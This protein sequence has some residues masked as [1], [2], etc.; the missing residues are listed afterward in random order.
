M[1]LLACCYND[2]EMQIDPDTVYPIRP[3]CRDDAPKTRFKPRPGLTLSPRRW[4]LLHNEEGCLDIAG[5]IKRVQRGGVHP[6]IKGEVW[7]FLLGCYDPKSTTEQRNQL[8]QQRRLEYEKLKTKCREMDT[9]VGSGRVITMPVITE[10]GQ[11]IENPNS[12]G[13][14]SV[15]SEQQTSGAP[16]PKEV[17]QWKL[18]LHQIGKH[19]LDVN[20]TD[21]V[22]V[23]YESQENLARLWDILAVYS[24]IDKDIGYCQGMSDLCSPISIILE[25]EADAFW[26]FE[27]LMRRVRGNFISTST[28]I[29][30]RAQLTTLSSIMKSVDP[31]LHEHLEN[32]DGG[33]Y[34]FA[35][36]MLMVLFRREFSFV[37]TMY[38]WEV[39]CLDKISYCIVINLMWSMEYNPNLF[40]MLESDTGISRE[41]TKDEGVLKQCGKFERKN[42]QA[43]KKDEIPLSIFV[44]ASV[45]E[46][47]NKKLLV[48]AKGL[49]DV[50]KILNEITGSLDAKKACREALQIHEKYLNT[51]SPRFIHK[52]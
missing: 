5:M 4:K 2:P 43:A 41:S 34:L 44:V 12:D 50:V 33:E 39:S 21:R 45:L 27:R 29:G 10:D 18:L 19:C 49:D 47:R 23:Y 25:H 26:C 15:G 11:P 28:S 7:E 16:L 31:K 3:D 8:R 46:A 51:V 1:R 38:L 22:L 35:F 48:E 24:W 9:T 13:G 30:V 32:L 40:S 52:S 14:T 36:R 17:I 42:L 37:D 6:T 20:R